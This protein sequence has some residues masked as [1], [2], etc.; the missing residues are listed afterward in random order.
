MKFG[1]FLRMKRQERG[2]SGRKL[3]AKSGIS[4]T[5]L[6]QMET[7]DKPPPSDQKIRRLAEV[8][9]IPTNRL[10]ELAGRAPQQESNAV[11]SNVVKSIRQTLEQSYGEFAER[12][13]I[14]P[15]ELRQLEECKNEDEA[16][17]FAQLVATITLAE[18]VK[19]ESVLSEDDRTFLR[20]LEVNYIRGDEQK[21]TMIRN[22]FNALFQSMK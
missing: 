1:E 2:L 9:E 12:L 17:Q 8:L 20:K 18:L 19:M 7:G 3:A 4:Q 5:Y 6:S 16:R 22:V 21:R 15:E 13:G 11:I 14:N 10:M